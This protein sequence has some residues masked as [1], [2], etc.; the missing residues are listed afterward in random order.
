MHQIFVHYSCCPSLFQ[1]GLPE[2]LKA[3][4][5][6]LKSQRDRLLESKRK[7]RAEELKRYKETAH[8]AQNSTPSQPSHTVLTED[9][10]K[11]E[12]DPGE[13]RRDSAT[14]EE[15]YIGNKLTP[16][17]SSGVLCSVIARKLKEEQIL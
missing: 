13:A 15:C 6:Y 17:S 1:K 4:E 7:A 3:R 16:K 14:R 10:R 5:K 11:A 2:E 9:V 12:V 8:P